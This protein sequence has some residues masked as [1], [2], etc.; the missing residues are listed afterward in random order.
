MGRFGKESLAF[1]MCLQLVVKSNGN[2]LR[3]SGVGGLYVLL[4]VLGGLSVL[5]GGLWVHS[6]K[7]RIW[8]ISCEGSVRYR[9]WEL[10]WLGRP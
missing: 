5:L 6:A 7:D 10:R 1:S 3:V 8:G 4:E 2:I 9:L